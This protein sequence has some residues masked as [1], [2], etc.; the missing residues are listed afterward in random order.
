VDPFSLSLINV[1]QAFVNIGIQP[2]SGSNPELPEGIMAIY[3]G[4]PKEPKKTKES[5]HNYH[6]SW[7]TLSG[8]G[9]KEN[10]LDQ[11]SNEKVL[12]PD[13]DRDRRRARVLVGGAVPVV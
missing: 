7:K 12:A 5:Q 1:R 8:N 2:E 11:L 3:F 13:R 10:S 6:N 4:S 9:R